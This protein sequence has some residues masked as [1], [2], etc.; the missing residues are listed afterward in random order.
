MKKQWLRIVGIVVAIIIVILVIPAKRIG[1]ALRSEDGGSSYRSGRGSSEGSSGW[2]NR[3]RKS[4]DQSGG[5]IVWQ[6]ALMDL[7]SRSV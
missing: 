4:S 3:R 2:R 7:S 1:P 6:E 5:R